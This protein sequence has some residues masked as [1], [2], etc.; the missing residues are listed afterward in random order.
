[1]QRWA[2]FALP[3]LRR[4]NGEGA[5]P[6]PV[7]ETRHKTRDVSV[8]LRR[9]GAGERLVF[10]HGAGGWPAWGAVMRSLA[11]RDD[12]VLAEQPGLGL[13]DTPPWLRNVAAV[14]MYYLDFLDALDGPPVHLIGHSLGGWIAA[15]LAVR[16]AARLNSLTVIAPA[17]V[18]VKGLP[19]GDNFIWSREE[20]ARHLFYDQALAEQELAR[21]PSEEEADIELTNRYMATKL[22]WEPRWYSPSLETWLH[23]I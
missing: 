22:G 23:R 10:L 6:M 21:V 20:Y 1:S 13:S 14:A 16:N 4:S 19:C 8:R 18:R 5:S 7:S 17:G 3:T 9:D 12:V 15:E 2:R 11:G